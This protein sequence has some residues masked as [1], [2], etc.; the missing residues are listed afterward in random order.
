MYGTVRV[1]L[2]DTSIPRLGQSWYQDLMLF[3]KYPIDQS[4]SHGTLKEHEL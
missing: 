4:L 2:K 1:L 3:F